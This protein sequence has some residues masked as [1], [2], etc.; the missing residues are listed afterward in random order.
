MAQTSLFL[1]QNGHN[2]S[3]PIATPSVAAASISTGFLALLIGQLGQVGA[4]V[5]MVVLASLAGCFLAVSGIQEKSIY[6]ISMRILL[7]LLLAL[8]FSW[9]LTS[10]LST[11]MPFLNSPYTASMVS[12]MIGYATGSNRIGSIINGAITKVEQKAGIEEQK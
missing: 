7:S 4:D 1:Y 3:D 5:M 12:L 9:A 2:M 10:I 8:I 11:V 6:K